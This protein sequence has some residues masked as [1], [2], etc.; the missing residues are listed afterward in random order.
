[1][2]YFF[3]T[4]NPEQF[5]NNDSIQAEVAS[6]FKSD[7]E[8]DHRLSKMIESLAVETKNRGENFLSFSLFLYVFLK[9]N[10]FLCHDHRL[11]NA[12]SAARSSI[13][14][15]LREGDAREALRHA[16]FAVAVGGGTTWDQADWLVK[17]VWIDA[18]STREWVIRVRGF[19]AA[20]TPQ[21][22]LR[23][24]SDETNPQR[25]KIKS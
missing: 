10:R 11:A 16:A 1:M 21:D 8:D 25:P 12:Y 5:F 19:T 9:E 7:T 18:P 13:G 22:N 14:N 4:L 2:E 17:Q 6:E 20:S 15:S 3:D 24:S 23:P